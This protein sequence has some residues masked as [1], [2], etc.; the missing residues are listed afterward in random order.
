MATSLGAKPAV[1]SDTT[2]PHAI[3]G[4]MTPAVRLIGRII[5][6]GLLLAVAAGLWQGFSSHGLLN[7]LVNG[8]KA[9]EVGF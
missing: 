9:S 1:V 5:T 6:A 4:E 3:E 2:L 8:L 7:G